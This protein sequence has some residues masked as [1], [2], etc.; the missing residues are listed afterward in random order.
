LRKVRTV[1]GSYIKHRAKSIPTLRRLTRIV[2][3]AAERLCEKYAVLNLLLRGN[4]LPTRQS[5]S[6]IL[7]YEKSEAI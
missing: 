7:I 5:K 6:L 2:G 4:F 3:E 1:L